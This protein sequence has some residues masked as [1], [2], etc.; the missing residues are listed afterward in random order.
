MR[1][2]KH[3]L[4]NNGKGACRLPNERDSER[5][6][7]L[8]FGGF[9]THAPPS[10]TFGVQHMQTTIIV[11][12]SLA[13]VTGLILNSVL[14]RRQR[15]REAKLRLGWRRKFEDLV[16]DLSADPEGWSLDSIMFCLDEPE[17]E[18][19]C[20]E[21]EKMPAGK[22]SLQKAIEITERNDYKRSA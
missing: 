17:W 12:L 10:R 14:L 20:Y 6:A 1:N 7:D 2:R 15:K 3:I 8:A 13:A 5:T 18:D 22:R 21:L 16:D 11:L 4:E 9:H 19:I